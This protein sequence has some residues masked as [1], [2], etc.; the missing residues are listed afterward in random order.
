VWEKPDPLKTPEE[1]FADCPW[2]AY[3]GPS[4][5]PYYF[6]ATTQQSVWEEPPELRAVREANE[7][8]A[9]ATAAAAVTAA[10]GSSASGA[11]SNGAARGPT[12]GAP[13]AGAIAGSGARPASVT[14]SFVG[15]PAPVAVTKPA[16]FTTSA[17]PAVAAAPIAAPAA[18]AAAT[19]A[20]AAGARV[21]DDEDDDD[22]PAAA[23]KEPKAK[24]PKVMPVYKSKEEAE[25]A[26]KALLDAK[27][28]GSKMHY[29][30]LRKKVAYDVRWEAIKDVGERRQFY[31]EYR[32][33]KMRDERLEVRGVVQTQPVVA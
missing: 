2:K 23:K 5:R 30:D 21:A 9:A 4:G 29:N 14:P 10:A 3:P 8:A 22:E 11:V 27:Y 19:P 18:A 20:A 17:P 15:G 28:V 13:M 32:S 25:A 24:R 12:A 6:N 33:K 31:S 16:L 1:R 7:A 26:F